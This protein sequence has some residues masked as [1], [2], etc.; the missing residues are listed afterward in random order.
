VDQAMC[1]RFDTL[2]RQ[3]MEEL[4]R[5]QLPMDEAA[6][7]KLASTAA[8]KFQTSDWLAAFRARCQAIRMVASVLNRNQQKDEEFKP[9]WTTPQRA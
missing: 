8:T 2:E 1:V 6:Y 5:R 4:K 9:N 3:A 7:D